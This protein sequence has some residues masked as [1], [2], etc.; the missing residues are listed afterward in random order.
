MSIAKKTSLDSFKTGFLLD[1]VN[2]ITAIKG[3][4]FISFIVNLFYTSNTRGKYCSTGV[5]VAIG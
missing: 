1:N 5:A 2:N 3:I 4:D